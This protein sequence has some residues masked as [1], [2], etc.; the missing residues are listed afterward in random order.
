MGFS[1]KKLKILSLGSGQEEKARDVIRECSSTA[2]WVVLLN[3]HLVPDWMDELEYL[4]EDL[5]QDSTNQDFRLWLTSR[6]T[7]RFSVPT[8][9]LGVK[10]AIEEPT[11]VKSSMSRHLFPDKAFAAKFNS[12]KKFHKKTAFAISLFHAAINERA[13]YTHCGWNQD[14]NFGEADYDLCMS[15]LEK[16]V[17]GLP[18]GSVSLSC[19]RYLVSDCT[20]GGR[21]E[22]EWDIRALQTFLEIIAHDDVT[23][24]DATFTF[25]PENIYNTENLEDHNTMIDCVRQKLPAETTHSLLRVSES[26]HW[27]KNRSFGLEFMR[28]IRQTREGH[29]EDLEE[30]ADDPSIRER[31]IKIMEQVPQEFELEE[32]LEEIL[33]LVLDQELQKYNN[34]I[35]TMNDTLQAALNAI[36]GKSLIND[37]IEDF[38]EALESGEIPDP[39]QEAA[40]PTTEDLDGFLDDLLKRTEFLRDWKMTGPPDSYWL[41][42]LFEPG[43]FL[44]AIM[45]LAALKQGK[46]FHELSL[47]CRFGQEHIDD[48][49]S[50]GI[51]ARGL[52]VVGSAFDLENNLLVEG[53]RQHISQPM[54]IFRLVPVSEDE[55]NERESYSCPLFQNSERSGDDNYVLNL[56]LPTNV[57]PATWIL[58]GVALLCQ[59]PKED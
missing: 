37:D 53:D 41:T 8:L 25:D 24:P 19:L 46:S 23:N 20:Y 18:D 58:R 27:S 39:W 36:D 48:P 7:E 28:K 44:I 21:M 54:P 52:F 56:N 22:D 29:F 35:S 26:N 12:F 17:Q 5:N 47:E 13:T 51:L 6:P 1:G 32:D 30:E 55:V 2:T 40:Y 10:V 33:Q 3:C 43:D 42:A 31:L 50:P 9:Q 59:E 14:Y 11:V 15:H 16:T 57:D 49:Q 45:Y 38:L 4:C 34:L